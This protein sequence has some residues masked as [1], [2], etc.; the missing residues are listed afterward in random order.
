MSATVLVVDDEKDHCA[1]SH[2]T[3]CGWPGGVPQT[4]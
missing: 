3:G 2:A 4:P 1:R